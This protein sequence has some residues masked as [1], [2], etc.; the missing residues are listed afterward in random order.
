MMRRAQM[1]PTVGLGLALLA[2]TGC[3]DTD[4]QP[5]PARANAAVQ[6]LGG[7]PGNL[8]RQEVLLEDLSTGKYVSRVVVLVPEKN[9]KDVHIVDSDGEVYDSYGDFLR[10]NKWST[11]AEGK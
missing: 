8:Y 1:S 11:S 9:G 6:E 10:H 2:L 3:S 4:G 7:V 5:S